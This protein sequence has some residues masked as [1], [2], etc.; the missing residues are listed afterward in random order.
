MGM[1][2]LLKV[3][4]QEKK[5]ALGLKEVKK[6]LKMMKLIVLSKDLTKEEVDSLTT[7]DAKVLV[8]NG[9]AYQLGRALGR[10]HPVK[11]LGLRNLNERV[12][13]ELKKV[14]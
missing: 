11:A 14:S 7:K 1:D 13:L 4:A 10:N 6:D 12:E 8:Y 2:E 9:S 3:I 5:V